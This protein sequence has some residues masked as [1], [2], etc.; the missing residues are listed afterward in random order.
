MM[1]TR[2]TTR[3]DRINRVTARVRE[4]II[5]VSIRVTARVTIIVTARV[6]Q[7]ISRIVVQERILVTQQYQK[8]SSDTNGLYEDWAC[9]RTGDF[10]RTGLV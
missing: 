5:R 3:V 1:D 9:M 2:L 10:M 7:M 6:R 4:K 8:L